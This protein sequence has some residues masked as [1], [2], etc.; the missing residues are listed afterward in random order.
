VEKGTGGTGEWAE[1]MEDPGPM[2]FTEVQAFL[3]EFPFAR[4]SD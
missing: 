1:D 4:L 2:L 3:L